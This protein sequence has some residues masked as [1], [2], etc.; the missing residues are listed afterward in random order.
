MTLYTTVVD[1]TPKTKSH[2]LIFL[3]ALNV[4]FARLHPCLAA[5][6]DG[7]GMGEAGASDIVYSEGFWKE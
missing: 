5:G 4:G 6:A 3:P 2:K 7:F 1:T